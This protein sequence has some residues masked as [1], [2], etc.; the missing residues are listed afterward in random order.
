MFIY[1]LIETE[2]NFDQGMA[3]YSSEFLCLYHS[4]KYSDAEFSQQCKAA[5]NELTLENNTHSK[6]LVVKKLMELFGYKIFETA[7]SYELELV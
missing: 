7:A 4:E 5:L 6:E 1:K 2:Y 3:S